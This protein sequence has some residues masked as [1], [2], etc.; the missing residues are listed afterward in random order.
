MTESNN[1]VLV[2]VEMLDSQP[3]DLGLEMLGLE[4]DSLIVQVGPSQRLLLV[5]AWKPL[6]SC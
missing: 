5:L 3:I 2:V 4:G 6:V 1:G